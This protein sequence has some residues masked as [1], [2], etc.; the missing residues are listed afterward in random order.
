M[1]NPPSTKKSSRR[2]KSNR[3]ERA[4][5]IKAL[6]EDRVEAQLARR[7]AS[8]EAE[9]GIYYDGSSL[10]TTP[11]ET[12]SDENLVFQLVQTDKPTEIADE[13]AS[14]PNRKMMGKLRRAFRKTGRPEVSEGEISAFLTSLLETK[15]PVLSRSSGR[16][17]RVVKGEQKMES[18]LLARVSKKSA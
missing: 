13:P 16:I 5:R 14:R 2:S 4:T 1:D 10:E 8:G 3:A 11:V 12:A 17:A 15:V 9:N 7:D 18:L 6:R